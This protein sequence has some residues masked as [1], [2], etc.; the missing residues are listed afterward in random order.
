MACLDSGSALR[1]CA[2]TALAV[3]HPS[4]A[5]RREAP[6]G[7]RF[8]RTAGFF[9]PLDDVPELIRPMGESK[10]RDATGQRA[11]LLYVTAA[12]R[13]GLKFAFVEV[14]FRRYLKTARALDLLDIIDSL[15][16]TLPASL[17]K[18]CLDR[19]PRCWKKTVQRARLVRVL[20]FYAHK[21]SDTR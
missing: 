16:S 3:L 5:R 4:R 14:K 13:G 9:V 21:G 18:R 20:R 12:R 10:D 6:D 2:N 17:R 1:G 15:S 8:F 11:D 19:I 7:P